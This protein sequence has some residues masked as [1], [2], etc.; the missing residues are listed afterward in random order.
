MARISSCSQDPNLEGAD[1]VIG[2]DASNANAT[3]N[4]SLDSL[5][6]FFVQSGIADATRLG[7]RFRIDGV[8][9][10][11]VD[12][13]AGGGVFNFSGTNRD[14][15]ELQN[16]RISASDLAG[17]GTGVLDGFISGQRIKIVST[18]AQGQETVAQGFFAVTSI[19]PLHVG[20][21][22]VGYQLNLTAE[23]SA[24]EGSI[25]YEPGIDEPDVNFL[26]LP[27]PG[28]SGTGSG[29]QGDPGLPVS[30]AIGR[31]D[32][33]GNTIITFGTDVNANIGEVTVQRGLQGLQGEQGI[34]GP[35]GLTGPQGEQGIQGEQG[36]EGAASTVPGP[37]GI[38]GEVGPA[39]EQ[40]IQGIQ[41]D[42]LIIGTVTPGA[43]PGDVTT[44]DILSVDI[45]PTTG[46]PVDPAVTT[47]ITIQPGAQ[48]EQGIQGIQGPAGDAASFNYIEEQTFTMP[49]YNATEVNGEISSGGSVDV[50]QD[51]VDGEFFA[52][53]RD[54]NYY[55][56]NGGVR[57]YVDSI[58]AEGTDNVFT[59][60]FYPDIT[61]TIAANALI[62]LFADEEVLVDRNIRLGRQRSIIFPDGTIQNSAG[63]GGGAGT[64][65]PM[66]LPGADGR[67]VLNGTVAP[68]NTLGEDGDFYLQIGTDSRILFGPKASGAWPA[69]GIEL[70]GEDGTTG[71][72][73]NSYVFNTP[74]ATIRSFPLYWETP[75]LTG[76]TLGNG[77]TVSLDTV[78]TSGDIIVVIDST[79]GERATYIYT[80]TDSTRGDQASAPAFSDFL[81]ISAA[82]EN[83]T[84]DRLIQKEGIHV[85]GGTGPGATQIIRNFDLDEFVGCLLYTSP[86][87]RDS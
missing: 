33:N 66:G 71:S 57:H 87:P 22:V 28:G 60:T 52:N 72:I 67:T 70:V 68:A 32:G 16:I 35:I 3:V 8:N 12:P 36:P 21:V 38:Q 44:F 15:A 43:A 13:I 56:V 46:L 19:D 29:G 37:Q 9:E 74:G 62:N 53:L 45:D 64:Q 78:L 48:G 17:F 20:T 39:G 14:L 50:I 6:D 82:E 24:Q 18:R 61:E 7:Y 47:T 34:Q 23:E 51:N 83:V 76:I 26:V 10:T 75:S 41:G 73:G 42:G 69:T 81:Q 4:F 30:S 84:L 59:L 85:E 55:F 11:T 40:G 27:L 1:R 63:G 80:G 58:T 49:H 25:R 5:G 2:T 79:T 86:S 54:N 31:F 77:G 65:G